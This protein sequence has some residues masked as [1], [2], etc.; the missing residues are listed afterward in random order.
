[1]YNQKQIKVKNITGVHI[2]VQ[3]EVSNRD[4]AEKL[5]REII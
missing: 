1:M 3:F 5:N 2:D 4:A